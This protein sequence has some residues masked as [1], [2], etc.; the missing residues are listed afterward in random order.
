[1]DKEMTTETVSSSIG[2][3]NLTTADD[4]FETAKFNNVTLD[5][6]RK[7]FAIRNSQFRYKYVLSFIVTVHAM[8]KTSCMTYTV[9]KKMLTFSNHVYNVLL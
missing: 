2:L 5:T 8:M 3:S 6:E 9:L 1:M 4:V 7:D